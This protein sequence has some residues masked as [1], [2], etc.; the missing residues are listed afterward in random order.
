MVLKTGEPLKYAS[1]QA[2]TL[3]QLKENLWWL[4]LVLGLYKSFLADSNLHLE[5]RT[6]AVSSQNWDATQS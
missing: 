4:K 5:L 1:T 2:S 6:A 3:D